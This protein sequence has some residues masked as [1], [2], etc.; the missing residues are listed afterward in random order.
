MT[1]ASS[2]FQCYHDL[3]AAHT[4]TQ[5]GASEHG[6]NGTGYFTR[7]NKEGKK[8]R[9]CKAQGTFGARDTISNLRMCG[10]MKS[11]NCFWFKPD[12]NDSMVSWKRFHCLD[13]TYGWPQTGCKCVNTNGSMMQQFVM[14]TPLLS[15]AFQL[16]SSTAWHD[17]STCFSSELG[18]RFVRRRSSNFSWSRFAKSPAL[19]ITSNAKMPS[20]TT[21]WHCTYIQVTA[22]C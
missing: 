7:S 21:L 2:I 15:T 9:K 10:L 3:L 1:C 18:G 6:I 16:L 22:C 19:S 14:F 5:I 8:P 13:S 17:A 12:S 20:H 4:H 11:P